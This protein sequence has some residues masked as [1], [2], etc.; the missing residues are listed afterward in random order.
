MH[1]LDEATV[2]ESAL[3][4]SAQAGSVDAYCELAARYRDRLL[5]FLWLRCG[6]RADAEDAVQDAMLNAWRHIGTYNPRWQFSTW[7]YRI[8]LRALPDRRIQTDSV[9]SVPDQTEDA[10]AAVERDN[11]WRIAREVLKEEA[12]L[13]LWLHYGEG[14]RMQEIATALE[15]TVAWVKVS[16]MR[17]R[18]RLAAIVNEESA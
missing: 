8:A 15:R 13:A 9:D 5:R 11:I 17:S 2:T 4:E 10:I 7:L 3:V 1:A 12:V 14:L 18:Q 16:L 6:N